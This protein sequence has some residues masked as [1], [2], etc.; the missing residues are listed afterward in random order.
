MKTEQVTPCE[1]DKAGWCERHR[2]EKPELLFQL[3]RR[4]AD[5][6]ERWERGEGP[7]QGPYQA[8][9]R[10]ERCRSRGTEPIAEV[11]CTLCGAQTVML[12]VFACTLHGRCTERR[13]AM[14][15]GDR[16]RV[17]SCLTCDDYAAVG[18]SLENAVGSM[19]HRTPHEREPESKNHEQNEI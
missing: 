16:E 2:C 17:S 18:E 1:C 4:R 15:T 19:A 7:L 5:F 10:R 11:E 14:G 9:A 13:Y 8:F 3:C 12:P 6:F